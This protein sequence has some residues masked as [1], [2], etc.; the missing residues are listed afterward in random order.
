[1]KLLLVEDEQRMAQ[2]LSELLRLEH[3]EVKHCAD[4]I[5]GRDA[6]VT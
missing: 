1:M 2:A 3:Y 4:W 5:K 6:A